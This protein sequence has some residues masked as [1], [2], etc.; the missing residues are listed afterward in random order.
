MKN[1]IH[2]GHSSLADAIHTA[3]GNHAEMGKADRIHG[4]DINEAYRISLSTGEKVFVKKN[5]MENYNFFI[6]EAHG[7]LALRKTEAIGVPRVLGMGTEAEKGSSFLLLEYL[8]SAPPFKNYWEV[9]GHQLAG[10]HKAGLPASFT[11]TLQPHHNASP[12]GAPELYPVKY[13]FSED[14]FIGASPQKNL[15]MNTWIDFY[16]ECRLLP[17]IKM[18]EHYLDSRL[19][20]K[21]DYLLEHL[22]QYLREPEFPSLLHGDLWSGNV[23]R[24]KDGKAWILDPAVYIG[25]FETDLAM[26]QLF[27]SF[28]SAFYAA[29]HEVNPIDKG[30]G[31]RRELYHL[32]HLLN[33]LNLFGRT[34][35]G[36]V[37]EILNRYV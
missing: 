29:Y 18:A 20:K 5:S 17:Q 13:G 6:T 12:S 21:A 8:E 3:F 9:F 24:G 30:Y 35:L 34:Y 36:S 7:L 1:N 25:D 22:D 19:R 26:T 16:R 2:M 10:M 27:G 14:N 32:Y 4:G 23:L 31:D 37:A 15:P 28:P 11:Y 33:H